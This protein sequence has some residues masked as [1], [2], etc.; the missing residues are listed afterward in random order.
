[1]RGKE[2]D[3]V[4]EYRN[5]KNTPTQPTATLRTAYYGSS[6]RDPRNDEWS[7]KMRVVEEKKYMYGKAVC[8]RREVMVDL[9]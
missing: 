4:A 2:L 9:G 7:D 6:A 8:G 1:M 5:E 3:D